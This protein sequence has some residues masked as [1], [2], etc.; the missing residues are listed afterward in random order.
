MLYGC[1]TALVSLTA[2]L[3]AAFLDLI[4]APAVWR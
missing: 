1:L 4:I 3:G 2:G